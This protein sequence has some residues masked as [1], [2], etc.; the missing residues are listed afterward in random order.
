MA[1][2][3]LHPLQRKLLSENVVGAIREAIFKEE[4]KLGQRLVETELAERLSVSRGPIRE[5]LRVLASGGLVVINAHR[6]TF[7]MKPTT[8]DLEE[9]YGLRQSLEPLAIRRA[10]DM[11][12]DAE[13]ASLNA[14]PQKYERAKREGN[15]REVIETDLDFH[16]RLIE[17]AQHKRLSQIWSAVHSQF[18]LCITAGM[19]EVRQG[20]LDIL[21]SDHTGIIKALQARDGA[22]ARA[23][24]VSHIE[25]GAKQVQKAIE[26]FTD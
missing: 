12:T 20:N 24:L 9:I 11:A 7:V 1:L 22:Q 23:L 10:V 21:A 16:A 19:D 5:A 4:L 14:I 2:K 8:K 18:R 15:V 6:G 13:I 25:R 26:S 3:T 17:L